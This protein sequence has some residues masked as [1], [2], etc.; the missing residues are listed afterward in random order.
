M[1]VKGFY[2]QVV[3]GVDVDGVVA[4][5]DKAW[6]TRY[7]KDYNDN[8]TVDQWTDWDI[9]L[10]IKPECGLKIYEYI[11]DPKIYDEVLPI[12]NSLEGVNYL[13]ELGYRIVFVTNSTLGASG[14]KYYWLKKYGFIEDTDD[15]IECKDK[16]LFNAEW[17]ID[18]R[19]KN[20]SRFQGKGILFEQ[21]WNKSSSWG[22]FKILNWKN[23]LDVHRIKDE[24][25]N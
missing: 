2:R 21:P 16:S 1:E 7:N 15:Y 12:D 14:A 22:G 19:I 24:T 18:D 11:E 4:G 23:F 17:L 20:L 9:H 10:L 13:R 25:N 8:M 5:L 6:I 3:F